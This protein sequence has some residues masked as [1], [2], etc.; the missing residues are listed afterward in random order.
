M[1]KK[2]LEPLEDWL[3]SHPLKKP[4]LFAGE[5]YSRR[6]VDEVTDKIV[7]RLRSNRQFADLVKKFDFPTAPRAEAYDKQAVEDLFDNLKWGGDPRR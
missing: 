3:A 1:A 6:A 2:A 4:G 7:D 5:G